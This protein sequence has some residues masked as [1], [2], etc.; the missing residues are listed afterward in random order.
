MTNE[1][2]VAA[3]AERNKQAI[4]DALELVLP[5]EGVVLEVAS[6]TGQHAAYFAERF[7][8]LTWQPSDANED[9]LRSIRAYVDAC[10][11][12]NLRAPIVFDTRQSNLPFSSAGAIVCINMIHISPWEST[13]GLFRTATRLLSADAP[14]ITYGPYRLNG[15]HTAPSNA[16]F[17]ERLRTSNPSWG[18]RD[19][20]ELERLG[21]EHGLSL[22]QTIEMPVN[23]K[24][25]VWRKS[26]P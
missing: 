15:E 9:D 11:F 6:G 5:N 14:L 7:P 20:A 25:L 23:N 10:R 18:V 3:A 26:T 1:A 13:D 2:R 8:L 24:T 16:A 19:I 4:A 12:R 17:D 21:A 22:A